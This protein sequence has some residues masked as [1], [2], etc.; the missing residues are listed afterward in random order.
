MAA[1]TGWVSVGTD[2]DTAAFAV[3]SIARWWQ[4]VGAATYSTTSRLLICADGGGSNGYRTRLW[5]IGLAALAADSGLSVTVCHLPLRDVGRDPL[6][7]RTVTS[8][9]GGGTATC[10]SLVIGAPSLAATG[11]SVAS[12]AKHASD[13]LRDAPS[14]IAAA[15]DGVTGRRDVPYVIGRLAH[16]TASSPPELRRRRAGNS[17]KP[18]DVVGAG[19]RSPDRA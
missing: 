16:R 12:A 14:R 3:A 1:D 15:P 17:G 2:H 9:T 6:P 5:K 8:C 19:K 4:A 13:R 7:V 11:R 18:A 10:R